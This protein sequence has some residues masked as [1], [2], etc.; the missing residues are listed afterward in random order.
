MA[1][2]MCQKNASKFVFL[3]QNEP[4]EGGGCSYHKGRFFLGGKQNYDMFN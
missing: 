1:E 2:K 3:A 4:M